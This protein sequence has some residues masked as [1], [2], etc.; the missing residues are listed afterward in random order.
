MYTD[1]DT[2]YRRTVS[3]LG[4]GMAAFFLAGQAMASI[5]TLA[6]PLVLAQIAP[7]LVGNISLSL[8][9][10][11]VAIYC[12]GLPVL[13]LICRSLSTA[14]PA[15]PAPRRK[16]NPELMAGAVC[17]SFGVMYG[18][19]MLYLGIMTALTQLT[20]LPLNSQPTTDVV[21]GM[22]LPSRLIL[23]CVLPP[24]LEEL[25]FRKYLYTKLGG[26]GDRAYIF[27]SGLYFG[28]FHGN[29]NQFVYAFL[30]GMVLAWLYLT[31]GRVVWG[32][33]VHAIINIFGSLLS[34]L[35][36]ESPVFTLVFSGLVLA[37]FV[38][39]LVFLFRWLGQ[40]VFAVPAGQPRPTRIVAGALGN[41]GN[42]CYI[43]LFAVV[44]AIVLIAPIFQ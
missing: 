42:I 30:L 5:L 14:Q 26:Y 19:N 35:A 9:L 18:S 23:L 36:L 4:W 3:R 44:S 28:L 40:K 2:S 12:L 22:S 27:L 8:I 25:V 15:S 43:L 24:I 21:L 33:V 31:T 32:M 37:I 1:L 10:S 34:P 17:L 38:G 7:S 13:V 39:A 11:D 16:M 29:L 20:G 6:A 41:L